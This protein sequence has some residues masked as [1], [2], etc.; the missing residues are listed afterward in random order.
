MNNDQ[1]KYMLFFFFGKLTLKTTAEGE[2]DF[3][4]L[5]QIDIR[6]T[7]WIFFRRDNTYPAI[8]NLQLTNASFC[9]TIHLLLVEEKVAFVFLYKNH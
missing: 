7:M 8:D 6:Q 2:W 4:F 5:R 3:L 9:T 1:T